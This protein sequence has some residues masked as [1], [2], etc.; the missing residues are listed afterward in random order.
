MRNTQRTISHTYC[1]VSISSSSMVDNCINWELN[2]YYSD[3]I[4]SGSESIFRFVPD[5]IWISSIQTYRECE[6]D[7]GEMQ[8]ANIFFFVFFQQHLFRQR[9]HTNSH[10]RRVDSIVSSMHTHI[11]ASTFNSSC[12][13]RWICLHRLESI[14]FRITGGTKKKSKTVEKKYVR[15]RQ[16]WVLRRRE[17]KR[18]EFHR[19]NFI[20]T[21]KLNFLLFRFLAVALIS[22]SEFR[23]TFVLCARAFH[24]AQLRDSFFH[25]I[26]NV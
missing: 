25:T 14:Q 13:K 24:V 22:R 2:P 23:S 8:T 1:M 3:A 11:A 9:K 6:C 19:A 15:S 20:F 10:H 21:W 4:K 18:V 26:S 16:L 7:S 17:R 5:L 12:E